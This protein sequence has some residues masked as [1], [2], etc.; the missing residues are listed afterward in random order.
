MYVIP[1]AAVYADD[2]HKFNTT[3]DAEHMQPGAATSD[4]LHQQMHVVLFMYEHVLILPLFTSFVF[5]PFSS[6][7]PPPTHEGDSSLSHLCNTNKF[8]S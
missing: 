7:S 1:H 2:L 8:S 5:L 3:L 4:S 6:N